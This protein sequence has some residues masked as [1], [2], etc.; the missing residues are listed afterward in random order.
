MSEKIRRINKRSGHAPKK[1]WLWLGGFF[2]ILAILAGAF[3]LYRSQRQ[4]SQVPVQPQSDQNLLAVICRDADC[5]WLNKDGIAFNK[6]SQLSGNIVLNLVDH[7]SR[8]LQLNSK[9]IEPESLAKLLFLKSNLSQNSGVSLITAETQ[10]ASLNDF[11]FT[12]SGGW[13]IKLNLS[14]NAYKILETLKQ[15]LTDIAKTNSTSTLDYLDL[16]IPNKVYYKFK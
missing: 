4:V 1:H 10:D 2:L 8:E 6:S 11:D 12:T 13:H 5:Y 3:F 16:R 7:T 15:A 9:M 14:D